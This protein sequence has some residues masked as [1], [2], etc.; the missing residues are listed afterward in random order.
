MRKIT[1]KG[2][3]LFTIEISKILLSWLDEKRFICDDGIH[4]LALGYKDVINKKRK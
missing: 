4:T 2:H 3:N 1:S